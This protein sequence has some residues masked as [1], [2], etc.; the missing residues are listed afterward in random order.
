MTNHQFFKV[1]G[2]RVISPAFPSFHSRPEDPHK[3]A[4]ALNRM[5]NTDYTESLNN[6]NAVFIPPDKALHIAYT[7]QV[8]E[9][10]ARAKANAITLESGN[11]W[12]Q[13]KQK[14]SSLCR[15]NSIWWLLAQHWQPWHWPAAPKKLQNNPLSRPQTGHCKSSF[16]YQHTKI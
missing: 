4:D 11:R 2:I 1:E 6:S 7:F 14:F 9:E 3:T 16:K 15:R 13:T 5:Y 12:S 8:P 10:L